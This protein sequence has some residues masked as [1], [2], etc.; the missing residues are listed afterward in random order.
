MK[1][2]KEIPRAERC[3]KLK[4]QS[5]IFRSE[6]QRANST[7]RHSQERSSGASTAAVEALHRQE[8]KSQKTL[9][10]WSIMSSVPR[11]KKCFFKSYIAAIAKASC[12]LGQHWGND[13]CLLGTIV[14]TVQTAS[15]LQLQLNRDRALSFY[16]RHWC[17]R[18]H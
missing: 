2:D 10:I 1:K 14:T 3:R 13:P 8:N 4:Q 5:Q 18:Q 17:T 12:M 16:A 11:H 6:V 7:P 9:S 15:G